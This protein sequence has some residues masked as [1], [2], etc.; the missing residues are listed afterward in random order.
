MLTKEKCDSRR[1]QAKKA[2]QTHWD[3]HYARKEATVQGV[4][5]NT[6]DSVVQLWIKLIKAGDARMGRVMTNGLLE[7]RRNAIH[8]LFSGLLGSPGESS[9]SGKGGTISQICKLLFIPIG[10]AAAVR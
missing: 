6:T 1:L 5:V 7:S 8:Y 2:V 9:W 3:S 10:S 4:S